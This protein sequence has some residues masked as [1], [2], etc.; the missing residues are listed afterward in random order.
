MICEI[1]G[2]HFN[3]GV[4]L[5]LEG[6]LVSACD[7]CAGFGV[8]VS[9]ISA[10]KEKP[11]SEDWKP[12][13]GNRVY[14]MQDFEFEE[15]LVEDYGGRIKKAREKRNLKQ[16]ELAKLINEPE[17]LVHRLELGKIE[18]GEDLIEKLEKKLNIKLTTKVEDK[19][20]AGE[21]KREGEKTLGDV[22]VV[23]KKQGGG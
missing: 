7:N 23:R 16:C 19:L 10:V 15:S 21:K 14:D 4:K 9:K 20:P 12:K 5:K 1:C 8:V 2:K 17:S 13:T 18:P 22:V 11:K 3:S 6:S